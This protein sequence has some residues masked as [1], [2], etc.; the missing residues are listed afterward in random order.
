MRFERSSELNMP[1]RRILLVANESAGGWVLLEA[2]RELARTSEA[3]V[4][5]VAPERNSRLGRL[6]LDD[7][8]A[9]GAT[10]ARL[11][12]CLDVLDRAG[13]EANGV[14]GDTDPLRA[15]ADA[16]YGFPADE[17]EIAA[18]AE[19]RSHWLGRQLHLLVAPS[20]HAV[21]AAR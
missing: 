11:R 7:D 5:V 3:E 14:V 6:T 15:I 10:E 20:R 1:K 16:L 8:R 13:I 9:P 12:R 4:L 18:H 2:I 19:T 17:L 21:G